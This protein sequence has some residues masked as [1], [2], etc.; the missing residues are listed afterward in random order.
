VLEKEGQGL[1]LTW[2]V[3]DGIRAHSKGMDDL[4]RRASSGPATREGEVVLYADRIAYLNHDID[5]ARR[6]ELIGEEDLPAE[7]TR[8][9][10]DTHAARITTM[11]R[12]VIEHSPEGG[13]V[14]MGPQVAKATNRLK[15]FLYEH[16]YRRGPATEGE[17][18]RVR[19]T[20]SALFAFYMERPEECPGGPEAA[21]LGTKGLARAVCDHLAGMTDRFAA[22]QLVAHFLPQPWR[23]G[24]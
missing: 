2:E 18:L 3:R 9:L 6:A 15:D 24:P 21:L 8:L 4:P 17:S 7:C 5:D 10:G 11:V 19:R 22:Q 12:D 23:E 13:K 16:V 20:I 1:N 14:T